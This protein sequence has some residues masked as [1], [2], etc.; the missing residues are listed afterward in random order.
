MRTGL[1]AGSV[2][3]GVCRVRLTRSICSN[4]MWWR[5]LLGGTGSGGEAGVWP[6]MAGRSGTALER[7][8]HRSSVLDQGGRG[9][10]RGMLFV[11]WSYGYTLVLIHLP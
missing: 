7:K 11:A 1:A 2:K 6:Q 10:S 9:R 5:S 4:G 3:L 8:C